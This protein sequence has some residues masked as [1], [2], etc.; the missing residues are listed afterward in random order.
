MSSGV[1]DA[2]G[3]DCAGDQRGPSARSTT[4]FFSPRRADLSKA[5]GDYEALASGTPVDL[6]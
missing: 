3:Q 1:E 6:W 4:S 5:P 2:G